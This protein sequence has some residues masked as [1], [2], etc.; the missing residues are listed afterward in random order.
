MFGA[1]DVRKNNIRHPFFY[2]IQ[3]FQ[4]PHRGF[5]RVG[6][7]AG[8]LPQRILHGIFPAWVVLREFFL[9]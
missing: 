9:R 5:G 7:Y 1:Y 3:F 6:R 4:R 2:R 8:R